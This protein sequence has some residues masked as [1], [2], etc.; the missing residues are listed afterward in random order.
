MHELTVKKSELVLSEHIKKI[1]GISKRSR[2]TYAYTIKSYENFCSKNDLE[3]GIESFREWISQPVSGKTANMRLIAVKR[4]LKEAFKFD[5]VALD[6]AMREIDNIRPRK[7]DNRIKKN[8]YLTYKE[9][10]KTLAESPMRISLWLETLFHT[11][12]RISEMLSVEHKNCRPVRYGRINFI[13]IRFT[14]KG[15]KDAVV[16]IRKA[17]YDRIN[18]HFNGSRYLFEHDGRNYTREHVSRE[19]ARY[20]FESTGKKMSAHKI[21]H[22]FAAYLRDVKKLDLKKIQ[23]AMRHSRISTT[24]DIYLHDEITPEE[25]DF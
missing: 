6:A 23:Q 5:P 8:H 10:E 22:S 1:T 18:K 14:G 24:S 20:T 9:I 12:F 19:I 16:H 25:I 15:N 2:E 11:G 13:E 17:L 7:T 3:Y 4:A 21:R